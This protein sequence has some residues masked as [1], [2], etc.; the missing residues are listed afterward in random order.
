MIE[1]IPSGGAIGPFVLARCT[2]PK[3]GGAP[4]AKYSFP[5]FHCADHHEP[6]GGVIRNSNGNWLARYV[7]RAVRRA[8]LPAGVKM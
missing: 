7:V 3:F 2:H 6:S 8:N 4:P 5:D 1:I